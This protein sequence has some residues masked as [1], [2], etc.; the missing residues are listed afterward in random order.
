MGGS[1]EDRKRIDMEFLVNL[2]KWINANTRGMAFFWLRR[3]R[4]SRAITYYQ[5]VRE[6][7]ANAFNYEEIA[8]S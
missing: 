2:I 3:L 6:G 1:E 7:G 8:G 4:Y 5:A